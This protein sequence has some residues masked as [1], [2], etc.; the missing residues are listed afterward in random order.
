MGTPKEL[1]A[2]YFL[3][4]LNAGTVHLDASGIQAVVDQEAG[5]TVS[6]NL[7]GIKARVDADGTVTGDVILL[8]LNERSNVDWAIYHDST[9]DSKLGGDVK[10]GGDDTISAQLHVDQSSASGAQPVLM[11]DQGDVSEE[12]IHFQGTAAS[13]VLTQSLVN[14]GDESTS[15]AAVWIKV[16]VTDDGDQ[17]ADQAYYVLGYTLA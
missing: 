14:Y 8:F 2:G 9:A 13:G 15:T 16:E 3:A 10:I 11:L 12:F 4:D 1:R 17:V 5:N 6:G 7:Y